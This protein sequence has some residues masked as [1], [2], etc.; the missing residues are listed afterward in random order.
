MEDEITVDHLK[1][2]TIVQLE[3]L[4]VVIKVNSFDEL[5]GHYHRGIVK[6]SCAINSILS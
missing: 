3:G 5:V 2:E 6:D 4:K 1:V